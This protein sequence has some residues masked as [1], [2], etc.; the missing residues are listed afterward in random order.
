M[1]VTTSCRYCIAF[2]VMLLFLVPSMISSTS[3]LVLLEEMVRN[4]FVIV[5]VYS[6]TST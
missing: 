5:V 2:E 6:I 3:S 4:E 1:R